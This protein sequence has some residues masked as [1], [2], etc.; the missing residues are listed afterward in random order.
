MSMFRNVRRPRPARVSRAGV[1]TVVA[2]ADD[3]RGPA[4]NTLSPF[5]VGA[6]W[7]WSE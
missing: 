4:S 7:R 2:S 3:A 5:V 6:V 1:V